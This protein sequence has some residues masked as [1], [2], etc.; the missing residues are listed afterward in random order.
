MTAAALC[1]RD[2]GISLSGSDV[3]ED[4]V[5]K[6]VL[7][8]NHITPK[9]GFDPAKVPLK[10]DVLVYTG[11]HHGPQ[12]PEV[13]AA[14]KRN[15]RT[16]SHAEAV[17]EL[18]SD[19]IGISVC[20]VG[21]KTSTSSM[22]ANI[23]DYAALKPSFLIGVGKIL[24]L[25][26]PGRYTSGKHFIAEAD[27]Y[28]VSPGTDNSP[29]FLKQAPHII[30]CTNISHDHPDIYNN[31]NATKRAFLSFFRKIPQDGY[32]IINGDD[33]NIVSLDLSGIRVITYGTSKNNDW[34][35]KDNQIK[36]QKNLVTFCSKERD[37]QL[38]LRVP[39]KFNA[40]NALAAFIAATLQ[41][42]TEQQAIEGLQLFRGSMRRFEK[43]GEYQGAILYDDYA[44]HPNQIR[45]TIQAAKRWLPMRQLTVIFQPHTY[46]RTKKLFNKFAAAF[47]LA[48]HV[49]VTDIYASKREEK[50]P[51]ISAQL[52]AQ[53]ITQH[54]PD[55]KYL[56]QSHIADYLRKNLN[57]NDVA[58]TMGA[59]DIYRI[60]HELLA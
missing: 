44:H 19:K 56:P 58:M 57:Y 47:D 20:G 8:E 52:L 24:N 27:E 48:D 49:I 35:V 53:A 51:S 2:L 3:E 42:V 30:I 37:I 31:I 1:I 11:A 50:D 16:I 17:G 10:T 12:N 39:G 41:G 29:R 38:T 26:V 60:H 46:T 18:M 23:L 15:I 54:H 22:I 7:H 33:P 40:L 21:G 36:D 59:G 34:W 14:K 32:L 25:Q 9:I 45:A 5:T 13:I 28:A 43:I 4:F 6:N 55:T